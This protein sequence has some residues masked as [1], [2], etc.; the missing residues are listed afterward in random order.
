[1][2][3][4]QHGANDAPFCDTGPLVDIVNTKGGYG[5]PKNNETQ[6]FPGEPLQK[7]DFIREKNAQ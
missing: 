5:S 4:Q 2:L 1:M 7:L 3:H 6:A